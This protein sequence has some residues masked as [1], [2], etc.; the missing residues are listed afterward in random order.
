MAFL[1]IPCGF[2][3]ALVDE[4]AL[5]HG[6]PTPVE[7]LAFG[8][9]VDYVRGCSALAARE[10]AHRHLSSCLRCTRSLAGVARL[11]EIACAEIECCAPDDVIDEAISLFTSEPADRRVVADINSMFVDSS[12]QDRHQYDCEAPGRSRHRFLRFNAADRDIK[13]DLLLIEENQVVTVAGQ[14]SARQS[15]RPVGGNVTAYRVSGTSAIAQTRIGTGGLFVLSYQ[16]PAS[17]RLTLRIP[18]EMRSVELQV[19]IDCVGDA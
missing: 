15:R 10:Q 11:M 13:T 3:S 14:I 19:D 7:H 2:E 8:M 6:S 4:H 9:I 18:L 16:S 5:E 1:R 12:R 17:A